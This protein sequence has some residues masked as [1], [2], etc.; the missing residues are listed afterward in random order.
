MTP[1]VYSVR[2]IAEQGLVGFAGYIV[3]AGKRA[4]IRDVNAYNGGGA[5]TT[6]MVLHGSVMQAVVVFNSQ[7]QPADYFW[8]GRQVYYAG[9]NILVQTGG[10]WDVTISGYL[11]DDPG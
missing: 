4:V 11:F 9:E 10:A 5:T 7:L 1:P 8:V 6:E 3:P 2:F